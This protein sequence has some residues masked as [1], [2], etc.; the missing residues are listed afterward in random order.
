V[1]GLHAAREMQHKVSG[2][3]THHSSSFINHYSSS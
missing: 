2:L 3:I 1:P